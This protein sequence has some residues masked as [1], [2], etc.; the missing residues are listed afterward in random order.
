MAEYNFYNFVIVSNYN[1][2]KVLVVE[3]LKYWWG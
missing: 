1:N 2:T 3:V